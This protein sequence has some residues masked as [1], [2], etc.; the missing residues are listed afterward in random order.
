MLDILDM[1]LYTEI[2]VIDSVETTVT[3][4]ELSNMMVGMP[5]PGHARHFH[6]GTPTLYLDVLGSQPT[7]DMSPDERSSQRK[8]PYLSMVERYGVTILVARPDWPPCAGK[9]AQG[10]AT[11]GS[12]RTATRQG[13]SHR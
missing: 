1:S 9:A 7:H 13:T 4:Y 5:G 3:R 8:T 11:D 12:S 10:K 6:F 2:D